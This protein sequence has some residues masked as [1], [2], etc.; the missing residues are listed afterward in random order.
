[1]QDSECVQF[2]QN[3]LPRLQMRW[4]GFRKVRKQVCKRIGRRLRE[5]ELAD[6]TAYTDYLAAHPDEWQRLDALCRISISRFYRDRGVFDTLRDTVLPDLAAAAQRRGD[7]ALRVWSA[8][9]ASGEEPYTFQLLW[10]LDLAQK[11]SELG[12]CITATDADEHLLDRARRGV[13]PLGCL[14]ELPPAWISEA[15]EPTGDGLQIRPVY[16]EGVAFVR[17]DIRETAPDGP[18]DLILCR[19]L[20]FTYFDEALQ[21]SVLDR[22]LA[23]LRSGGYLVIGKQESLPD[24]TPDLDVLDRRLPIYRWTGQAATEAA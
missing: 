1:M 15:F 16:R 23:H 10:H 19:Y 8:G 7:N 4:P 3:V 14:K 13:Y 17:Q 18:F 11:F 21:R 22:L 9:C 20:A 12:L 2:L 6:T 5:L 24:M